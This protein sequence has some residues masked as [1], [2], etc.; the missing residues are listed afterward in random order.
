MAMGKGIVASRIGQLKKIL[1]HNETA[2]LVEP[3]DEKALAEALQ[4]KQIRGA[5]LDVFEEEPLPKSSPLWKMDNVI[6]TS[7]YSGNSPHYGER[8]TELFCSNLDAFLTGKEMKNV[9]D[10][11]RGY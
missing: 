7:H 6:I 10:L 1:R 11:K 8:V 3:E 4:K 9:V 5:C 2:I